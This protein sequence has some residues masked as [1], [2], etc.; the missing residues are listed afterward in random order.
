MKPIK[1][2]R[3]APS[4]KGVL[5]TLMGALAISVLGGCNSQGGRGETD[6]SPPPVVASPKQ[7]S[8][9]SSPEPGLQGQVSRA[10]RDSGRSLQGYSCNL[11]LIGQYQGEGATWVNPI[12]DKC[13]YMATAFGGI[14]NKQSQGVQVVD[15]SDPTSP[16]LAT[17]L[18]SSAFAMGT[19]ESLSV[20]EARGL[21]AGVGVGPGVGALAFDIY[22]ISEDCTAPELLNPLIGELTVPGNILGHEGLFSPDGNTY[23][24]TG[25]VGGEFTAIDVSDPTQPAIVYEGSSILSNHGMAFNPEGTRMYLT[26]AV[27]AGVMIIDVS[28]IQNRVALPQIRFVS[29]ISW[30]T[31]G[32]GQHAIHVTY[33]GQPYLIVVDEFG[34]EGPKFIDISDETTPIIVNEIV[35]EIQQPEYAELRASE[36]ND[37]GVFGYESHYC[38]VDYLENPTALAC[39]YFQS[40]IRVFDIRNPLDIQEIAYFNPGGQKEKKSELAG[41]EH[42]APLSVGNS[43][44]S[45]SDIGNLTLTPAY[46]EGFMGSLGTLGS[47]LNVDW[48]SSAPRFV[49]PDQLWV[50]CQDNGFLALRFA[51]GVYPIEGQ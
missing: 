34:S 15:V 25:V 29:Q 41:S 42:A 7:C 5:A 14:L 2:R 17:N 22:D 16:E 32:V 13:A 51:S 1:I 20:N 3:F 36:T 9:G 35:L 50:V 43:P 33:D 47:E 48:C 44:V 18:A 12:T 38:D 24:A 49:P 27:P 26:T 31:V 46:L 21:L 11:E 37:E 23:W 19:W 10:D 4:A 8:D 30:A 45:I 6:L 28:D 39:G 40:G